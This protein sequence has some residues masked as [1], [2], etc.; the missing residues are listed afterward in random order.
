MKDVDGDGSRLP[1]DIRRLK[2]DLSRGRGGNFED[3]ENLEYLGTVTSKDGHELVK[4]REFG[5][6]KHPVTVHLRLIMAIRPKGSSH[7]LEVN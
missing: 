4:V 2:L 3:L 1:F 5:S 7:Y 6:L